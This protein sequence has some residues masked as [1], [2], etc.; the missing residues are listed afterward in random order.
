MVVK[1]KSRRK[2]GLS[3]DRKIKHS[4]GK[5]VLFIW[6]KRPSQRN[7]ARDAERIQKQRV[8]GAYASFAIRFAIGRKKLKKKKESSNVS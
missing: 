3:Q 4:N 2:N 6:R 1:W 8:F 5:S 7:N